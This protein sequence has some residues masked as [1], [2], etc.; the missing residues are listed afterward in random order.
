MNSK[1]HI[2]RVYRYPNDLW[3]SVVLNQITLI[4]LISFHIKPA[5]FR[6]REGVDKVRTHKLE[7]K[8]FIDGAFRLLGGH[9]LLVRLAQ[10][11]LLWLGH[12]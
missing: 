5:D 6:L 3:A 7:C 8:I 11:T 12:A 1:V 9:C 10:I 4:L 2:A